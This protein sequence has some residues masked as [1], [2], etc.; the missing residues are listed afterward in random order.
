MDVWG[1]RTKN[2]LHVQTAHPSCF[3]EKIHP[4][5][6]Q[7]VNAQWKLGVEAL[8][9]FEGKKNNCI[10]LCIYAY[11]YFVSALHNSHF[12]YST[13]SVYGIIYL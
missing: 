10:K 9:I 6:Q 2:T 1:W 11:F 7:R 8:Q 12:K 5:T 3:D 4:K 13:N